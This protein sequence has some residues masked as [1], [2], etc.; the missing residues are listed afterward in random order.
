MKTNA[1]VPGTPNLPARIRALPAALLLCICALGACDGGPA[2][3]GMLESGWTYTTGDRDEKPAQIAGRVFRPVPDMSD[4]SRLV[5]SSQDGYVWLKNEFTLPAPLRGKSC[6]MLLGRITVAD[7]A[8]LN[9]ELLG[10]HGGFPPALFREWN[11]Y[12]HYPVNPGLMRENGPNII[13]LKVYVS[14]GGGVSGR[15]VVAE[16]SFSE[17]FSARA[18]FLGSS[19][20]GAIALLLFA[21]GIYH[22]F[23]FL[24]RTRGKEYLYFALLCLSFGLYL[25]DRFFTRLP[26]GD[27]PPFSYGIFSKVIFISAL[28]AGFFFTR[29]LKEF[30]RRDERLRGMAVS[31]AI[32]AVPALVAL[33]A[34]DY[35][36][37]VSLRPLFL[38]FL[39]LQIL[40]AATMLGRALWAKA[41]GALTMLACTVPLAVFI[42]AAL[43]LRGDAFFDEYFFFPDMGVAAFL[44][45]ITFILAARGTQE[46]ATAS[47]IPGSAA[48]HAHAVIPAEG[49]TSRDEPAAAVPENAP[50]TNAAVERELGE[51]RASAS[52]YAWMMAQAQKYLFTAEPPVCD[53]WEIARVYRPVSDIAGEM[54]DFHTDG[55]TLSGAW[56]FESSG[57]GMGGGLVTLMLNGLARR[58]FTADG[59]VKLTSIM[60]KINGDLAPALR[61][62]GDYASGILLRFRDDIVEY[63][64][65]GHPDLLLRKAATGSIKAVTM[66]DRDIKGIFLGIRVDEAAYTGLSFRLAPGDALLLYSDCLSESVNGS[67]EPY[68]MDR[69]ADS[70]AGAPRAGA[71]DVLAHISGAFDAFMGDRTPSD[72]LSIIVIMKT[73]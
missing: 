7:E 44:L 19:L 17:R 57:R 14:D 66:R 6:S 8:W 22:L 40:L 61:Q 13:L 16:R 46:S 28:C 34:P 27:Q 18:E 4:L 38:V 52:R 54:H 49:N 48:L 59:A 62:S 71:T 3:D 31:A 63:V 15:I 51:A 33:F 67:G 23:L 11:R 29:F 20:F 55:S 30:L 45:G 53:G 42:V 9:G 10:H 25:A 35:H 12:R 1:R 39:G 32:L 50:A 65:A 21:A 26:W 47:S 73:V 2:Q 56:L 69:V 70:L 5:P 43:A 72:D 36:A 37:L 24:M 68:G 64:N 60:E 41:D 58:H